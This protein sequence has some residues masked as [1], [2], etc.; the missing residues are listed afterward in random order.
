[1]FSG[2]IIQIVA[3]DGVTTDQSQP[4]PGSSGATAQSESSA[5]TQQP[6]A[7]TGAEVLPQ[8]ESSGAAAQ[9][10]FS[11]E[12]SSST[13]APLKQ[14]PALLDVSITT[15]SSISS[16]P[17][18]PSPLQQHRSL[19]TSPPKLKPPPEAIESLTLEIE[20]QDLMDR[21]TVLEEGQAHMLEMQRSILQKQE[22]ILSRLVT[23]ENNRFRDHSH[24]MYSFLMMTSRQFLYHH[25]QYIQHQCYHQHLRH[26]GVYHEHVPHHLSIYH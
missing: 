14:P 21:V 1:M 8:P 2:K 11:A 12:T 9:S 15:I 7:S 20:V 25:H 13:S 6:S 19:T 22:D 17:P 24:H 26:Q 5:E 16:V 4:Q 23:L 18:L 10:E 3:H